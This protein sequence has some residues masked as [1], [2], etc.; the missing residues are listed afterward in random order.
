MGGGPQRAGA[1]EVVG[2]KN[3]K[4]RVDLATGESLSLICSGG[5]RCKGSRKVGDEGKDS[6]AEG[7]EGAR[8]TRTAAG[9]R[10][11]GFID[12]VCFWLRKL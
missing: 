1:L 9:M 10:A 7:W 2:E 12:F 5:I 4:R 3:E 8:S 6:G 11:E